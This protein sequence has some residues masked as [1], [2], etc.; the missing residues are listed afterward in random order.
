ML[1]VV[2]A[3]DFTDSSSST[4][5]DNKNTFRRMMRLP[6]A[7]EYHISDYRVYEKMRISESHLRKA[8]YNQGDRRTIS[9]MPLAS[10]IV[11]DLHHIVLDA[12]PSAPGP[13]H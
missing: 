5:R 12:S 9:A 7:Q 8:I 6:N 1:K 10:R 2:P 3:Y 13:N 11:P 4:I